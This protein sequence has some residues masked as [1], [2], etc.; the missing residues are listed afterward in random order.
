[1]DL[2]QTDCVQSLKG[3]L[4]EEQAEIVEFLVTEAAAY[5][6]VAQADG[7]ALVDREDS[8]LAGGLQVR[9]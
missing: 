7:A 2:T 3:G 4:P 1:M 6:L 5:A 8:Q 9:C